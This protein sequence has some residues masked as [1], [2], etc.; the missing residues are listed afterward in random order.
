[1]NHLFKSGLILFVFALLFVSCASE[2]APV[3]SYIRVDPFSISSNPA[4]QGLGT[5]DII[6]AK[7]FVN[8]SEIGN[9]ELPA[10]IPV[11]A[12]GN[13]RLEIYPNIKENGQ[14]NSQK[15]YKPYEAHISNQL[16]QKG[17]ITP[18]KPSSTYRSSAVFRWTEDFEDQGISLTKSGGNNTGDSLVAIPSSTPGVDQPFSGSSYCGYVKISTDSFAVFER[19]TLEVFGD[20]PFM[21]SDIYVEMDIKTN[22]ALQLGIYTDD[23]SEV[24]QVPVLVVNPTGGVWKKIYANLKTETGGLNSGTKVRLFFGLYKEDGD[25]VDKEL[26]LDNLKLIFLQ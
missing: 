13:A 23:G 20:L 19:S 21:G 24:R 10:T 22:V 16:L 14:S 25:T 26:Y 15:Y 3:P 5:S 7:V 2:E 11:L 1:M 12:E 17:Q 18:V 8:G 9:F 4:T 6:S